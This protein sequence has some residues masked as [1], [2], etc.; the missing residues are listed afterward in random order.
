MIATSRRFNLG[1]WGLAFGYFIFYLPYISLIKVIATGLWPGSH[2][3]VSGFELLPAAIIATAVVL[4]LIVICLGWWRHMS[5]REFFGLRVPCPSPWLFLSGTA[6][7]IIVGTTTLAYTFKG[8]PL[9]LAMVILR[10]GVL[11]IA[12]VVDL[13]LKRRVRWFSWV[14]LGLSVTALAVALADVGNYKLTI[15]YVLIVLAYLTGYVLR[16]P[17]MTVLAKSRDEDATRRY[18]VEEMMVAVCVL[19]AVPA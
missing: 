2:Q 1:I 5:R 9:V 18:F 13:V 8:V 4:P 6:T 19:V 10:A 16:L 3:T 15:T 17:C 14:A 12:P 11:V 7:A